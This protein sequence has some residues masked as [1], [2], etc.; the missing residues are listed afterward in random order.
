[1]SRELWINKS[2]SESSFNKIA[3]NIFKACLV[4]IAAVVITA[5][6]FEQLIA[7]SEVAIHEA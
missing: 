2:A 4:G 7:Q 1:M 3:A 6:P 5:I